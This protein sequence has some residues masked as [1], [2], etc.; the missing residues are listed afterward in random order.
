[1]RIRIQHFRSMRIRIQH[2]RSM[3]IRIQ[4]FRSMRIRMQH[5][6]LMRIRI[7]HFRSMRIRIQ[8]F[9]SMRIRIQIHGF[10]DQNWKK[11]YSWKTVILFK[12]KIAIYLSLGLHK[13]RPSY[14][15]SR[16]ASKEN[17]A[18]KFLNFFLFL[19]V[20]FDLLDLI[21]IQPTKS[22]RIHADPDTKHSLQKVL[23]KF[24]YRIFAKIAEDTKSVSVT[25]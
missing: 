22:M 9:S 25:E 7:Q 4:H 5:F 18:K 10:D 11:I 2:F 19:W 1:M 14:R 17:T 24:P 6:R 12:S 20:N 13:G 16:R 8:H 15:R 23:T 3:R 21:R